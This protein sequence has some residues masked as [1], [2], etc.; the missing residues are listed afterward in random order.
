[1]FHDNKRIKMESQHQGVIALYDFI[2][3]F[4]SVKK[5]VIIVF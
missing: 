2:D 4:N 3:A 5:N 1:M